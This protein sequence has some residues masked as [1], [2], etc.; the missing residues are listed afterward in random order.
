MPVLL[1]VAAPD[2]F[3]A[4]ESIMVYVDLPT[5]SCFEDDTEGSWENLRT[6]TTLAEAVN[7]LRFHLG[8]ASVTDEGHVMLVVGSDEPCCEACGGNGFLANLE[9]CD[10]CEKFESDEAARQFVYN[11]AVRGKSAQASD[12]FERPTVKIEVYGGVADYTKTG[13]VDVELIDHDDLEADEE[14]I[15]EIVKRAMPS[16]FP[17]LPD[18]SAHDDLCDTCMMSGREIARTEDGK[19]VCVECDADSGS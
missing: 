19:T 17:D 16:R 3:Q 9:R 4:G 14:D 6:F 2:G 18:A 13:D 15:P 1:N 11:R 12:Y 5:K 7:F 8:D 10:A